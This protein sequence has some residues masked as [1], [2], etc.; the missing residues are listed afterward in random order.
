M[1]QINI[2]F[3]LLVWVARCAA[4]PLERFKSPL[5]EFSVVMEI[6]FISIQVMG[7][8]F[9]YLLNF[10]KLYPYALFISLNINYTLINYYYLILLFIF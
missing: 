9:M 7:S 3:R 1:N 10:I 2:T 8:Q 4:M 5:Q 6:F